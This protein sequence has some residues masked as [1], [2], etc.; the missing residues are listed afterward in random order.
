MPKLLIA[1]PH[2]YADLAR[3][4]YRSIRRDLVPAFERAGFEV[5]VV[6][7]ADAHPELFAAVDFPGTRLEAASESVRDFVEFY[8]TLLDRGADFL[9]L[10]DAD[11]FA[12]DADSM[13]RRAGAFVDPAVV[14][15][16]YARRTAQPGVFALLLRVSAYQRLER[17][18]FAPAYERIEEWPRSTNHQP[19]D[20]AAVALRKAGNVIVDVP[21]GEAARELVD[22]HATTVIRMSRE[23]LAR[24]L[25][26][27]GFIGMIPDKPYFAM[28]AYDN[29]LIGELYRALYGE[30]FAPGPDGRHLG[31]SVTIEE[32]R[33]AVAQV[34]SLTTLA[35][36]VGVFDRSAAG[37]RRLV[38]KEG[39]SIGPPEVVSRGRAP[40]ARALG[41][42]G[43]VVSRRLGSLKNR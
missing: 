38:A 35:I 6:L 43:L 3:L 40:V 10:V 9:F 24:P 19:G 25:G 42:I 29:I 32:L 23:F 36:V 16:S 22:F 15:I 1:S 27:A 11:L 31:G 20:L 21:P 17:P 28:G 41:R 13:A 2:R 33:G 39:L 5:E 26:D 8:E 14:A 30:P 37:F 12:L 18:V 7:F 4:W 34:R